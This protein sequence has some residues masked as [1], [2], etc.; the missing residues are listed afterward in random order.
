M[1][2]QE[3][4]VR[5]KP[6]LRKY[7][8]I[9]RSVFVAQQYEY[10][11]L[12]ASAGSKPEDRTVNFAMMYAKSGSGIRHMCATLHGLSELYSLHTKCFHR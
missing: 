10:N 9:I 2:H 12:D 7:I 5:H 6:P 3:T 4:T 11:V 1:P 8:L